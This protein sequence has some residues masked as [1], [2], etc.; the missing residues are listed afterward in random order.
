MTGRTVDG[1]RPT[2]GPTGEA[3]PMVDHPI[4]RSGHVSRRGLT[5]AGVLL[6]ALVI[7]L[8]AM[9]TQTYVIF[10][11]ETFQYLEQGHRLAF[12]DGIVP[13]EYHDGIRSWLLP[14]AIAA[15]MRIGGWVSDSPL[16]YLWLVRGACVLLSLSVVWAGFRC[17]E[18]LS[19]IQQGRGRLWPAVLCGLFCAV[20]FD[21]VWFAPVVLTETV[22][23]HL[24]LLGIMTG[25]PSARNR[26]GG[27][28]R[29]HV[30]AGACLGLAI[31]LRYQ[32][33]PAIALMAVI[34]YR[35]C[36][37]T[38]RDAVLG[39][40]VMA[41]LAG[42]LLD[43]ATWGA[44]FQ[45]I[46]LHFLRNTVDG[47]GSAIG[48]DPPV[49]YLAYLL[50]AFSPAPILLALAVLG[51]IKA[52]A[53]V[54]A[55]AVGAL[56]TL[57]LHTAV[58]HKEVRFIYLA[59]AVSPILIGLGAAWLL[60]RLRLRPLAGPATIRGTISVA[61]VL[62]VWTGLSLAGAFGPALSPRWSLNRAP[63][64][65]FLAANRLPDLCGLA[66]R[67]MRL[68]DSGGYAYL[69]RKVPLYFEDSAGAITLPGSRVTLRFT[70]ERDGLAEPLRPIPD[71]DKYNAMIAL[72]DKDGG[73]LARVACF[74]DLA[75]PYDPGYCLFHDPRRR[76]E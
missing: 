51:A 35:L 27:V 36:W 53:P 14:G 11:D 43:W 40:A 8:L 54:P 65:A 31:C 69:H 56:A 76:C 30:L 12:G 21:L 3:P 18:H 46:W 63:I 45:S 19:R 70:A 6:F 62:L 10:A 61:L 1:E 74:P 71:A 49:L 23:A 44:P 50:V 42:G 38:W 28:D 37:R 68:I 64:E 25:D 20:W 5:L 15:L 75:R 67:D 22:A 13:W 34:Q 9:T 47:V 57:L 48:V 55:L 52:P 24:V 29:R 16:A 60:D 17:G 73:G 26:A 4:T 33:A 66:V 2:I 39:G 58:P 59:L 41:L 7:R 72:D 32:Y